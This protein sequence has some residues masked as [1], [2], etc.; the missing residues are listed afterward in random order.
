MP[1]TG[2]GSK[3]RQ[4]AG[5]DTGLLAL[6]V[7]AVVLL[8]IRLLDLP[9]ERDEGEY[10]Y[11]AWLLGEGG[12]PYLDFYTMKWPG[13]HACYWLILRLG[14][15][16]AAAIHFGLL[17]TNL[18]SAAALY[19]LGSVLL[20]R[21]GACL[22]T[23]AFLVFSLSPHAHGVIANAEPFA[24]L[25]ALLGLAL[26]ARPLRTQQTWTIVLAGIALGL[27]AVMKQHAL[28]FVAFGA[29]AALLRGRLIAY[30]AGVIAVGSTIL[31][32]LW[33]VGAGE[34]F[35]F[36]TFVYP[37]SYAAR[38]SLAEAPAR[39]R[40]MAGFALE[41]TW[42]IAVVAALGLAL[43]VGRRE[44]QG[45]VWGAGL[46]IAA[47]AAITPGF[48][49]RE[50]YFLLLAPALGILAGYGYD[51]ARASVRGWGGLVCVLAV[52]SPWWLERDWLVRATPTEL[53]RAMYSVNPF[54]ESPRIGE[55]LGRHLATDGRVAIFGSE[56]QIAFYAQRRLASGFIYMYPLT[57]VHPFAARLQE[58]LIAD[59]EASRPQFAVL[60]NVSAS[61]LAVPDTEP[62]LA[63]WITEFL[64][65]DYEPCGWVRVETNDASL[66]T[67]Y[68]FDGPEAG[69]PAEDSSVI[70]YRRRA[71]PTSSPTPE[72][73]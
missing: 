28:A 41:A 26:L 47:L 23:A 14:G 66:P 48:Y 53:S 27:S 67:L 63:G 3:L 6:V 33:S 30:G 7:A 8:R 24:I 37:Q 71:R 62:L 22:A 17:L 60:V 46:A 19:S 51:W 49:F 44:R 42:P 72:G 52:V 70:I 16:S 20:S 12:R 15:A 59:V 65:R 57:E 39:L 13:V 1:A 68:V 31:L 50:H 9:L 35:R 34:A 18:A 40:A 43:V 2:I 29:V 54:V 58:Q 55:F 73:P 45:L 69:E 36:W 25:F 56:P 4:L 10:A 11:A 21:A 38:V 64:E 32:W 5:W 61:W